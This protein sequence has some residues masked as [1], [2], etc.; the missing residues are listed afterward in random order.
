MARGPRSRQG[1]GTP[2][3][4]S[5]AQGGVSLLQQPGFSFASRRYTP[6][7]VN[8]VKV[9]DELIDKAGLVQMLEDWRDEDGRPVGGRPSEVSDRALLC[10]MAV[11]ANEGTPLHLT[12]VAELVLYR[13]TAQAHAYLGLPPL[14]QKTREGLIPGT[15]GAKVDRSRYAYGPKTVHSA[16][17]RRT[18][19]AKFID[20]WEERL[21]RAERRIRRVLDPFPETQH[22]YRYDKA[23]FFALRAT[24]DDAFVARRRARLMA[25]QNA[26][27]W[28]V[29]EQTP[30]E[31]LAGW[32]GTVAFDGTFVPGVNNA[33][34]ARGRRASI[35]PDMGWYNRTHEKVS[36]DSTNERMKAAWGLDLTL[37][38]MC[39]SGPGKRVPGLL[40]G[41]SIDKPAT[42]PNGNIMTALAK[43]MAADMPHGY[44]IGDRDFYPKMIAE[45]FQ[46]PLR[47]AGFKIIGD[48]RRD[49]V[50]LQGTYAG[51]LLV[52]GHFFDPA[53]PQKMVT[54]T[55]DFLEG[56][57]TEDDWRA[58]LKRRASIYLSRVKDSRPD[59]ATQFKCCASGPGA[60]LQCPLR[61][62]LMTDLAD[63]RAQSTGEDPRLIRA[64]LLPLTAKRL[65][66]AKWT[67]PDRDD[68]REICSNASS[69]TVPLR[70]TAT[71][72]P[73]GQQ[74]TIAKYLQQGPTWESDEWASIYF[75]GRNSIEGTNARLKDSHGL[76]LAHH[77]NRMLR[78]FAAQ[79]FLV[80]FICFAHN[81][82]VLNTFMETE[83]LIA[84]DPDFTPPSK[85]SKPRRWQTL[86]EEETDQP[87][88]PP[89]AA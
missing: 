41:A 78:G 65:T 82:R 3:P 19:G 52:D 9:V 61:T 76:S 67:A 34:T 40:L 60:T 7:H 28:T 18:F 24:R 51:M 16:T 89:L 74:F 26:L 25:F 70:G 87:N 11:L 42:N 68:A 32:D 14:A 69:V 49:T 58:L 15:L 5:G 83:R 23:D 59:G 86:V 29:V 46:I 10:L 50:G 73:K 80:G 55:P 88:A 37:T 79:A 77:G 2:G 57:I 12:K 47:E 36:D 6:V 71:P 17:P 30:K 1:G 66:S 4:S 43:V 53:M 62:S 48:L 22:H 56:R 33:T 63:Q 39:A 8:E 20:A 84:T 81:L 85:P 75:T 44:A 13:L 45:Q 31:L 27:I 21:R 64:R 38:M 35:E 72:G 54:A